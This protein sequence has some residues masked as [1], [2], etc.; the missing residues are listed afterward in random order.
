LGGPGID[1]SI[2]LKRIIECKG[3]NWV[4]LAQDMGKWWD[5]E[6]MKN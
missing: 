4:Y 5:L 1:R 6:N 2:I 3:V